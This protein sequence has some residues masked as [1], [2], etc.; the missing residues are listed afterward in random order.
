MKVLGIDP[1]T[2]IMGWGVVITG[3]VN[4]STAGFGAFKCRRNLAQAERLHYL[5]TELLGVIETHHPDV[6]AIEQPFVARNVKSA[7]AIGRAE[8]I[9]TLAAAS[10]FIPVFHYSPRQVKQQVA[11][12]GAGSKE[13]IQQAVKLELGLNQTPK[14]ADA[15][16]AL[17]V[18]ICH[19]SEMKKEQLLSGYYSSRGSNR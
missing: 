7:M 9:A 12:Y 8:A 15:A 3:T 10:N 1:G 5:Y 11:N 14:P 4:I 13:Q 18:A 17:A 2:V 6:V 19:C 16:D